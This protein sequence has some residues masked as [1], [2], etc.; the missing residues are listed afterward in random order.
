L[1][2]FFASFSPRPWSGCTEVRRKLFTS[3]LSV[4]S[5]TLRVEQIV[6]SWIRKLRL[7]LLL[8]GGFLLLLRLL[9]VAD[10]LL[11]RFV[12][13]IPALILRDILRTSPLTLS[14]ET[15][16]IPRWL[17][18]TLCKSERLITRMVIR[19]SWWTS[20]LPN[21]AHRLIV[22][23]HELVLLEGCLWSLLREVLALPWAEHLLILV[24]MLVL[25]LILTLSLV[26]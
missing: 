19:Q 22:S 25:M 7:L 3:F 24:L 26:E 4:L 15:L 14:S 18:L 21:G 13:R 6:N 20:R 5:A 17:L 23:V 12:A 11:V 16:G 10:Q 8:V 1:S 9:H 2:L